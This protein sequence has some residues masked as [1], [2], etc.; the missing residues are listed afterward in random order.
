MS[1]SINEICSAEKLF[2][3]KYTEA[4][5]QMMLDNIETQIISAQ[6]R[7]EIN[8]PKGAQP[9][10]K[11]DPRPAGFV[12]PL[13]ERSE[14]TA[15]IQ[16]CFPSSTEE[17]A[18]AP[19]RKLASWIKSKEI[20][21]LELTKIY[22]HRIASHNNELKAYITVTEEAALKRAAEMDSLIAHG[23]YLG[24]LHGIP[25]G[26][27]DIF[28]TK[29]ILTTWGAEPWATNVPEK[30]SFVA[31]RL[32]EAGAILLGKTSVGALAYGDVWLGEK[33]KNPWNVNEGS[34]GSS[35]GSASATAAG[36]CAFSIGTETLG[37]ITS[38]SE[39]CG[40]VGLRPTFGRIPRTG[41]MS[42]CPSL[43]KIGPICRYVDD[44]GLIL[45]VL[46]HFDPMDR[47]SIDAPFIYSK[48]LSEKKPRIGYLESDF[49]DQK[50]DPFNR[51]A[52]Q[53]IFSLGHEN[54]PIKLSNFP[55]ECLIGT[56]YAEAAASFE[57]ITL[58]DIDDTLTRQ[59]PGGWPNAFRKARFLSAVD[60]VQLDRLRMMAIGEMNANFED[61][62]FIIGPMAVNTMLIVSNFT[63]HPCLQIPVGFEEL[64]TRDELSLAS[65]TLELGTP[66]DHGKKHLVPRGVSIW[67]PL[68]Q[69]D[70]LI[71][72]GKDIENLFEFFKNRPPK[73]S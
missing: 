50:K 59:D 1:V 22:L 5:R 25:Y 17:I 68:F 33:T 48:K 63:G 8:F 20:S 72:F 62:D 49:G 38:P 23:Q 15:E 73:F 27:K 71:N 14:N 66:S 34:S 44:C 31:Q 26:L 13:F 61:V 36:L 12:M 52:A 55:F 6:K 39:R 11:F 43:D 37:S 56:L 67:A 58:G 24:P 21:C 64:A 53:K 54:I 32:E 2:G 35:A 45:E 47:G 46:N 29:G 28:D 65:G 9:A 18:F 70:K 16:F 4:E 41:C 3:I 57:D 51:T 19:V 69:E 40:T 10:L 60:H 7:R 42:L 30:D